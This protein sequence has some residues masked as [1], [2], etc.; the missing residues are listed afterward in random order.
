[1]ISVCRWRDLLLAS[2]QSKD[3]EAI[4]IVG[5][6]QGMLQPGHPDN[7][8]NQYAWWLVSCQKGFDCA[9]G[10]DW[11]QARC[12]T[13]YCPEGLSGAEYI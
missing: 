9:A 13:D 6:A 11:I 1:M 12:P 10:S 4:F 7:A 8:V 3:P 5:L 2:I